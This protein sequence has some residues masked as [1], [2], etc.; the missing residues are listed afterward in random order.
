MI[1]I[2][3][4]SAQKIDKFIKKGKF[5]SKINRV[6]YLNIFSDD[7]QLKVMIRHNN[8]YGF[9]LDIDG[10][11]DGE[12]ILFPIKDWL[13][14]SKDEDVIIGNNMDYYS[15]IKPNYHKIINQFIDDTNILSFQ[16]KL[17][18]LIKYTAS[19]ADACDNDP[20]RFVLASI[21]FNQF[22]DDN[23]I[24][25]ASTNGKIVKE[26]Y[27][28]TLNH[29][30]FND[31]RHMNV[32]NLE[33][34]KLIPKKYNEYIDFCIN[35][36]ED[37]FSVIKI[38]DFGLTLYS[39]TGFVYPNYQQAFNEYNSSDVSHIDVIF[40]TEILY[41]HITDMI[42]HIKKDKLTVKKNVSSIILDVNIVETE[43]HIPYVDIIQN[44]GLGA[45]YII[46][47]KTEGYIYDNNSDKVAIRISC[48]PYYLLSILKSITD[49]YV[50]L[51]IF[52]R[53]HPIIITNNSDNNNRF[54]LM[55]MR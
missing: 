5:N 3:K 11:S 25:I 55:P 23:G 35:K 43:N 34:L 36:N 50:R 15:K 54:L 26:I 44:C 8:N 28:P 19:I 47:G 39:C 21:C 2:T 32:H 24:H 29:K 41:K 7:N 37:T 46:L 52:D 48:N 27:M 51:T 42:A 4:A 22:V 12:D 14:L 49:K 33:L 17:Q 18:D 10:S 20:D 30:I 31:F 13:L 40:Q 38:P 9:I 1:K 6:E 16:V 45:G 53:K